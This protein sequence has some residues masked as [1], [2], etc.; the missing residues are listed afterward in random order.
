MCGIA[1]FVGKGNMADLERMIGAIK[2]RGPDRQK[3][4]LRGEVGLAHAR[5]SILDLS[6]AGTQPMWSADKSVALVFNGEIYNFAQ[7]RRELEATQKY[8][9]KS[10]TDTEVIMYAYKEF[11]TDCFARMNGMFALAL[12][13]FKAK[14][15]I[16]ARDRMGKK[17]LYWANFGG[18]LIFGSELKA[19]MAH[20]AFKK[21]IDPESLNAYFTYEFVPTPATIFKRVYKLEP[22]SYLTFDGRNVRIQTYWKMRFPEVAPPEKR[23]VNFSMAVSELDRRL[24]DAVKS[25]LVADVPL[26]V[27][28]SGGLDSSTVAY[29]AKR[30][31]LCAVKTFSIGFSEA[32]F[33]E[34]AYAKQVA[35]FLQTEHYHKQLTARDSLDV[36]SKVYQSLDEPIGDQSIIP[37]YLLSQFTREHVTVALGG[38]GG[39]ELF[40][41]YPTFQA[42]RLASIYQHIPRCVRRGLIEPLVRHIPV[43]HKSFSLDFIA[44]RFISGF[45]GPDSHRH[46]KWL[47]SFS[48]A[49]RS[50]LFS[51]GLWNQLKTKNE[52][53][54]IDRYWAGLENETDFNSGLLHLYQRLYMMDGVM[55]KVDR[56]SMMHA[57]E[58]RA[59][60]LDTT[61]VEFA[62][63]LPFH[64]K[65]KGFTTKYILKK[66]MENKL[67]RAIVH[68][69]KKGF[70]VPVAAWLR[71]ELR[72]W[73]DEILS[74]D[75][76]KRV[77]FFDAEYVHK[78]QAEHLAGTENHYRK[79]WTLIVFMLWYENI[80]HGR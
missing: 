49:D 58:A 53:D 27:F 41:G 5:L 78:L 40:A 52:Y 30:N 21:E 22:A 32:S 71:G 2:H 24:S 26:G 6:E 69:K 15:L 54:H 38:D 51:K 62:N 31:S 35:D 63:S 70:G 73:S 66:L 19:L 20:P 47:G 28:L 48:H 10:Q 43:S 34:S 79:L 64:F 59:P 44:K 55:V 7:L 3:C 11:G 1:G 77:G 23:A 25:R 13:D 8:T 45:D 56:A 12:Y 74:D 68:R 76:L 67:P 42:E 4:E 37:M 57:L 50:R 36:I 29:Y 16:L 9:F 33:D 80:F 18:T 65:R 75:N 72:T 17:P 61:V 46:Q 14:K 60:F 39:D